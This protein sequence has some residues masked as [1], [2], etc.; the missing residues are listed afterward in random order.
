M[1]N[2]ET[3]EQQ[4]ITPVLEVLSTEILAISSEIENLP[5]SVSTT[6]TNEDMMRM[7]KIDFCSQRLVAVAN[8]V[9][10]LSKL[11]TGCKNELREEI[12]DH[13]NMEH[14]QKLFA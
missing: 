8:L 6:L 1:S 11:E 7:Q 12:K 13:I 10:H 9:A 3:K 4:E 2:I 14:I 5:Q